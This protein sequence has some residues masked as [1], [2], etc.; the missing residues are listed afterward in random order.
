M[1]GASTSHQKLW[2]DTRPDIKKTGCDICFV[3]NMNG[4]VRI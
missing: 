4:M 2:E 3:T 1:P